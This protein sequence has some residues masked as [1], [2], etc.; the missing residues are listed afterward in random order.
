MRC[1]PGAL[2]C[3]KGFVMGLSA[4]YFAE[5]MQLEQGLEDEETFMRREIST[6]C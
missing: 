1:A 2:R 6:F 5:E 3:L 4:K